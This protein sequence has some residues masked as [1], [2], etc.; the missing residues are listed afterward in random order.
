MTQPVGGYKFI[1]ESD[2]KPSYFSFPLS[3]NTQAQ[4]CVQ[5]HTLQNELQKYIKCR[6]YI[7]Y[8]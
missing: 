4:V 5:F 6:N 3:A 2:K 8:Y 7:R 1:Q